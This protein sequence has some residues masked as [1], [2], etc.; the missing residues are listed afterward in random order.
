MIKIVKKYLDIN[1]YSNLKK[2]FEELF[3]SHPNFPSVF[4][5]T[6]SLDMLGIENVAL[7]VPK[8]QLSELPESFL[9]LFKQE[10]VLVSKAEN[11]IGIY[12]EGG[13][14]Q[15]LSL[16]AFS[17]DWSG[18]IIALEPNSITE[19]TSF[20]ANL[21]WLKYGLPVLALFLLSFVYNQYSW[22]NLVLLITSAIGLLVSFFIVQEKLG[23][24]NEMISK[25]CNINT[26]TSCDSVI[27]S[28]N[29]EISKW[30]DFSDLPLTFFS[31]SIL[32]IL[33]QPTWSA[34]LVG[35]ASLVSVPVIIYSIWLQKFKLKK[36]CLLCL[37]VSF[38]I[39]FQSVQWFLGGRLPLDTLLPNLFPTLFS[40]IAVTSVLLV[41]KP[42][43]EDKI[44]AEENVSKLKKFK[45]NYNLFN[46]LSKEIPVEN[47]FEELEG[48]QFG[49]KNANIK[50]TLILSPSC[51]HCY[52]AFQDAYE[53]ILKFP[54]KTS[55]KVLFNINPENNSNPYKI[56]VESLLAINN[57]NPEKITEA[58]SDWF[59]KEMKLE[60]WLEKWKMK[61]VDMKVNYQIHSQYHWCLE[62]KFN[63][64]PV[65]IINNKQFPN[66]YEISE[67]KYFQNDFSE[68]K[69]ILEESILVE[70]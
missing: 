57:S 2:D 6:D 20:K 39:V 26:N 12:S 16:E 53:L 45:R 31:V 14:K 7:K 46:Y 70:P 59:T 18:V 52:K 11:S 33:I 56:V 42:V 27:Q 43:L 51:G 15:L 30:I 28:K 3:M 10:L 47:G 63:Y 66:E 34:Y 58:L 37:A 38:L 1:Y 9:A 32:A 68:E 19:T 25:L 69:E 36:W 61:T 48:I 17:N 64:T 54:E 24:K 62:N 23:V 44:K 49:N 50:L 67:L 60:P 29:N 13:E 55:L 5:I 65:T 35:F 21:N 4:A 41:L 8:D 22:N 40:L